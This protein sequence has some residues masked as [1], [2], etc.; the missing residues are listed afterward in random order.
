MSEESETHWLG[1]LML[2]ERIRLVIELLDAA[3]AD[4]AFVTLVLAYT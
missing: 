4:V 3:L 1:S 2:Y